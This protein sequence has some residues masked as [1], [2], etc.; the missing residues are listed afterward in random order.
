MEDSPDDEF[1][2]LE[3]VRRSGIPNPVAVVRDGEEAIAYLK[4]EER[5]A[6]PKKYPVP[7]ALF[8]DLRIPKISGFDVLRWIKTQPH[9]KDMLVVILTQHQE[10]QVINDAYELGAHTFLTKPLTHTE[11]SNVISH[12]QTFFYEGGGHQPPPGASHHP[13]F[14]V[15]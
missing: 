13:G 8:L 4:R 10:I 1:V 2:F 14:G 3:I 6:D 7:S 5:F 12:F 11:L 9:L 15:L